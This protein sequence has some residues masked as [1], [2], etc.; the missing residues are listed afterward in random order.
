M[1]A[2]GKVPGGNG[3][4]D[5]NSEEEAPYEAPSQEQVTVYDGG[6]AL[7]AARQCIETTP[8]GRCTKMAAEAARGAR[9]TCAARRAAPARNRPT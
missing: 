9:C 7:G 1:A 5:E 4:V 2:A 8:T 3:L 6:G